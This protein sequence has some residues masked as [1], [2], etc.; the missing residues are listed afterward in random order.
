MGG[1]GRGG[2]GGGSSFFSGRVVL[3]FKFYQQS[4][5]SQEIQFLCVYSI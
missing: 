4:L 5:D 3:Q 2:G 1:G